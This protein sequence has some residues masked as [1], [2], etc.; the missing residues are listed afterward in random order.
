M[1][2]L[3]TLPLFR[4]DDAE[5]SAI[6]SQWPGRTT[7]TPRAGCRTLRKCRVLER[8]EHIFSPQ[9]S[10]AK[11]KK[12]CRL[13]RQATDDWRL[14]EGTQSA[15]AM[16]PW[17]PSAPGRVPPDAVGPHFSGY[18]TLTDNRNRPYPV[19]H[20]RSSAANVLRFS[21]PVTRHAS[22]LFIHSGGNVSLNDLRRAIAASHRASLGARSCQSC[23]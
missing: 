7:A 23:G 17:Y 8:R 13:T 1:T 15:G 22:R 20:R 11:A 18:R 21:S 19:P 16:S 3:R 12:R 2:R 5:R 4:H 10:R 9:E 6:R 14:G